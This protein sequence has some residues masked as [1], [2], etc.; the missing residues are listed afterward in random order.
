MGTAVPTR[1][2]P[3]GPGAER[4]T[5]VVGRREISTTEQAGEVKVKRSRDGRRGHAR[6]DDG[7]SS[8]KSGEAHDIL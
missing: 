1:L 6:R 8:E 2:G 3:V 7:G 5:V 4:C